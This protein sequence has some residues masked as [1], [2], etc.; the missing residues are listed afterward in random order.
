M[1]SQLLKSGHIYQIYAYLRSQERPD[2]ALSR[3]STGVLLYPAIDACVDESATIQGHPI[4]FATVDLAADSPTI[5]RQ[6][7]RIVETEPAVLVN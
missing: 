4:R 1:D 7:L 3:T 2:D 5:R 6:L